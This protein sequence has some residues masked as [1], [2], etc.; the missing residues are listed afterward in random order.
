MDLEKT[1]LSFK[2]MGNNAFLFRQKLVEIIQL[3][4][5]LFL[6]LNIEE[7]YYEGDTYL[8]PSKALQQ[9]RD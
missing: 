8:D 7:I 9:Q 4:L 6:P 2:N 3:I 1:I 5:N